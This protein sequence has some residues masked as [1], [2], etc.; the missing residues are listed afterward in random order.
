MNYFFAIYP[1]GTFCPAELES[2]LVNDPSPS[3]SDKQGREK[4]KLLQASLR[5][6]SML[7]NT[8]RNC[9]DKKLCLE[10]AAKASGCGSEIVCVATT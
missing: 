7:L 10:D 4:N 6:K 5:R 2:S 9:C 8:P 3:S 1:S